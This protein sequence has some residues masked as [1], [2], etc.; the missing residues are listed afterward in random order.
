MSDQEKPAADFAM[1]RAVEILASIYER[2]R[3]APGSIPPPRDKPILLFNEHLAF[4]LDSTTRSDVERA[5]GAGFAYPA[6]GWH[7]YAIAGPQRERRLLS[8]FYR[9]DALIAVEFYA[10]KTPSAPQLAPRVL[11][12][13][14]L[15]PGEIALGSPM[16]I[17]D[18]RFVDTAMSAA[19][20]AYEQTFA[21]RTHAGVV[22]VCASGG[23]IERLAL[24][25]DS[26]R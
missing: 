3:S 20:V 14:R 4:A 19:G 23:V 1:A 16:T 25:F 2:S 26:P 6:E 12:D 7:T 8:A 24:Y 10:P 15:V 22:Y 9:D 13:F 11:G 17:L 5:L 21:A 18:D